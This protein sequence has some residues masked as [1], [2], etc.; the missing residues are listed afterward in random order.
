[1]NIFLVS[2]NPES[3]YN[4]VEGKHY[5]YP[6]GIPNGKQIKVGDCLIFILSSKSAQQL[7]LAKKRITGIAKID[8][9][10][11]YNNENKQMALASYDWYKKFKVPLSFEDLGGDPRTNINNAMN[12]IS[13]DIQAEILVNIIKHC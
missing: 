12:R 4:D 1:M 9:I 8:N 11:I 2:Q 3:K 13:K 10:T 7:N 5:D 6:T